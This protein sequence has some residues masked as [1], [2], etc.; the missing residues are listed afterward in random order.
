ML[1]LKGTHI[2][3]VAFYFLSDLFKEEIL[4]SL[5]FYSQINHYFF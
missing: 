3:S 1:S 2:L 4:W 5:I